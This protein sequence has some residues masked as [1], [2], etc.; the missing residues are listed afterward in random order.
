MGLYKTKSFWTAKKTRAKQK[1]YLLN[2]KRFAN[3]IYD[4]GLVY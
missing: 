1:G 3:Y 4:N 2:G